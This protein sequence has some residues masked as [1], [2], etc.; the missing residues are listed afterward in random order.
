MFFW[1]AYR[2]VKNTG[3]PI[4]AEKYLEIEFVLEIIKLKFEGIYIYD[5]KRNAVYV[6]PWFS[7]CGN[8]AEIK[9]KDGFYI[10]YHR[11]HLEQLHLYVPAYLEELYTNLKIIK[12]VLRHEVDGRVY[13][14]EEDLTESRRIY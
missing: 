13:I 14:T 8:C 12:R 1:D 4:K 9:T 2:I 10:S 7:S 11:E 6:N 5:T 3:A